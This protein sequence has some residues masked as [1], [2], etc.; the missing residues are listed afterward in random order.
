M[1]TVADLVLIASPVHSQTWPPMANLPTFPLAQERL[2]F[3][4]DRVNARQTEL[5]VIQSKDWSKFLGGSMGL[6]DCLVWS[7]VSQLFAN[8]L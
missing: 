8:L 1:N 6:T 2:L 4:T 7:I 3:R 5:S